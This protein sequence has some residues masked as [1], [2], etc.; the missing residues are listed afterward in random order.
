MSFPII[1]CSPLHCL[2]SL[3]VYVA[4]CVHTYVQMCKDTWLCEQEMIL[5]GG[6]RNFKRPAMGPLH[7]KAPVEH[8]YFKRRNRRLGKIQVVW[9]IEELEYRH[10]LLTHL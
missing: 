9:T 7:G 3:G 4:S 1:A 5:Q 6:I 8:F 2:C 10:T